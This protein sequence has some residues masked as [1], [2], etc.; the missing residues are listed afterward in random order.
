MRSMNVRLGAL[1]PAL[2]AGLATH[3]V[4]HDTWLL[5]ARFAMIPRPDGQS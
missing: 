1:A 4:A 3:A 2:L 5:P